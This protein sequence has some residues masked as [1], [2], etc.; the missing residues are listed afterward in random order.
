MQMDFQWIFESKL[1][2]FQ[3]QESKQVILCIVK[4]SEV[5]KG[6]CQSDYQ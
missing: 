3:W 2:I 5:A 4:L 1:F 6:I